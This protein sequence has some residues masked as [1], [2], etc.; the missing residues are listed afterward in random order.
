MLQ[1]E[2]PSNNNKIE[3]LNCVNSVGSIPLITLKIKT[4]ITDT[5]SSGNFDNP[6]DPHE[7]T[8]SI[9]PIITAVL[10]NG[11]TIISTK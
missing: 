4:V 9:K 6:R 3:I 11:V 7:Q 2:D 5:V 8:T 1:V 10:K